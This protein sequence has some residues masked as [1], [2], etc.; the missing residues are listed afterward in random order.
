MLILTVLLPAFLAALLFLFRSP[1]LNRAVIILF[2]FAF[3]LLAVFFFFMPPASLTDYFAAGKKE[4]FFFAVQSAVFAAVSLPASDYLRRRA[5]VRLPNTLYCVNILLFN[6]SLNGVI[7]ANHL[8]LMWVFIEATTLSS[9]YLIYFGATSTSLEAV[10]KYL[11]ICS[12]GIAFAFTGIILLSVG[13]GSEGRLFFSD[14]ASAAGSIEPFWLKLSFAFLLAGFGTK[15]ALA[16]MHSWL[17]DAYSESPSTVTALLAGTHLNVSIL[18]IMRI[19]A[20]TGSTDA[21]SPASDILMF[22][23]FLSVFIA[24][25]YIVK[26]NNFKRML[27]YSSLENMGIIAIAAS[28]GAGGTAPALLHLGAHSLI[29]TFLFLTAGSII[30][31]YG[32]KE[33]S[34]VSGLMATDRLTAWLW[35]GGFILICGIPPSPLFFSEYL[36]LREMISSGLYIQ[37]ALLFLMM[38]FIMAGM[39]RAVLGMTGGKISD[40]CLNIKIGKINTFPQTGLLILCAAA[41]ISAP[42]WISFFSKAMNM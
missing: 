24:A 29:K 30:R 8:G 36:I 5:A 13:T 23:G 10:W 28:L 40:S 7:F 16:P 22:T 39:G 25:V 3:L 34:S 41:G 21:G 37:S 27:S 11:F 14:L 4:L 15:A 42:A 19:F 33:I 35:I 2:S 20:L 12:I 32:T 38:T 17:P 18:A 6:A 1:R 9:A 31:R 26:V